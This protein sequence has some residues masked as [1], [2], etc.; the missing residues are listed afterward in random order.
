MAPTAGLLHDHYTSTWSCWLNW[1]DRLAACVVVP[2]LAVSVLG[3]MFYEF[4]GQF[5]REVKSLPTIKPTQL[6]T[7]TISQANYLQMVLVTMAAWF[8][9]SQAVYFQRLWLVSIVFSLNVTIGFLML[10]THMMADQ[11]VK[12]CHISSKKCS[13]IFVS[14][15]KVGEKNMGTN[16]A[17]KI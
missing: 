4:T 5:T 14:G 10:L 16:Q 13:M 12:I 6:T 3:F 7:A 11:Q 2:M 8:V 1:G 15:S 9:G 17:K